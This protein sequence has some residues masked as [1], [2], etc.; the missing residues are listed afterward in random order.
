MTL[1]DR[2]RIVHL[3]DDR[4][5]GGV[6]RYLDF[7]AND[8]EMARLGRHQ[9]VPVPRARPASVPVE[10]DILV[11]HLAVTWRGLPGLMLLR[12]SHPGTPMIHVEHSYCAGFVAANVTARR[13]FYALLRTGYSLFDQ[14]AAVSH[15]Q[16]AWIERH[17]LAAPP[18][19]S[20]VPPTVDLSP[21]HALAEPGRRVRNFALIGRLDRQKGF[22][23]AIEAF[24]RVEGGDLRLRIHGA[25]P[26]LAALRQRAA[27]DPRI[28][29]AGHAATPAEAYASA[30]VILM[31]SRWEPFGLVAR[32]ALA[33]GRQ[34]AVSCVDGLA[35]LPPAGTLRVPEL[36]PEAWRQAIADLA[37][38]EIAPLGDGL[39]AAGATG[40]VTAWSKLLGKCRGSRAE[41]GAPIGL[42]QH[43]A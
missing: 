21:F 39:R 40:T 41:A 20:I 17:G 4:T 13:R 19:L 33:A 3:I 5:P 27:G 10:A 30:E 15:S 32:E 23:V 18:A 1:P 6:T 9:V 43:G 14:I 22:D 42:L 26:D 7:I 25:G 34:V 29:F 35:E 2:P 8:P 16:A 38:R 36:D 37:G 31:P 28:S 12:A 11:S 24:R